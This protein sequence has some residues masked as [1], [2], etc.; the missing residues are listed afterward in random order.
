MNR[1]IIG[2]AVAAALAGSSARA[3]PEYPPGL[4]ENSPVVPSGPPTPAASDPPGAP[5]QPNS[6][7]SPD[8]FCAGVA[9]RTFQS[10]EEVKQAHAQC[11]NR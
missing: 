4:F 5:G 1:L 11:D 3:G 2:V 10:L 8:D 6:L 9:F 7:L